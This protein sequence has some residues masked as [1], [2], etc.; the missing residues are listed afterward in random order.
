MIDVGLVNEAEVL[1]LLIVISAKTTEDVCVVYLELALCHNLV[2]FIVLYRQPEC[3]FAVM[4]SP[5]GQAG[6]EAKILSSA[7]Y[8]ALKNCPRPRAFVLGMS[9]NFFFILAS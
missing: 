1:M 4:L 7:S 8:S 3:H 2:F 5:Q 9:S 6:L